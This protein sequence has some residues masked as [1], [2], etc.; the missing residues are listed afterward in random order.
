VDVVRGDAAVKA[1]E[2]AQDGGV[3]L[4]EGGF[5]GGQGTVV[6]DDGLQVGVGHGEQGGVA[7]AHTPADGGDAMGVDIGA[8]LE[9]GDGGSE[10]AHAAILGQAAHQLMRHVGIGGHLAAVEIDGEG[11]V[12]FAGEVLGLVFDPVVEAPPF[13]ND[14]DV[15]GERRSWTGD[16]EGRERCRR[17][18][19]R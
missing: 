14:D 10:V 18:W 5:I 8:M 15:Q 17:R 12:A 13:V 3:D 19:G 9:P 7:S 2:V 4:A 1:A 6:D 16:R 11:D